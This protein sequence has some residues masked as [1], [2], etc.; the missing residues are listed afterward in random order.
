MPRKLFGYDLDLYGFSCFRGELGDGSTILL[1]STSTMLHRGCRSFC[2]FCSERGGYL[3]RRPDHI[4]AELDEL[5]KAGIKGVFFD[6]STL[7]D[8]EGFDEL[9]SCLQSFPLQYGSLNRFDVLSNPRFV[10]KLAEAGFVYQYCAIEQFDSTVLKQ[11]AKGQDL[12]AIQRGVANLTAAGIQLGTSLLFGLRGETK[13]SINTTLDF[14]AA[15]NKLG[16]L[17][18]VSMSLYSYHPNT[19]LTLGTKEGRATHGLLRYDCEPPNKG[20][21]WNSFE[22]GQW[23]HPSW[24]TEERVNAI[25]LLAEER[26]GSKLVRNMKKD[27]RRI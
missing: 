20:E 5:V 12:D 1:P 6:D 11:N 21:P 19:P 14:V 22:E 9:L 26:I 8:H 24:L 2:I 25:R 18:C 23:F 27:G 13:D 7:G 4:A 15:L 10:E 3:A 17:S 16:I